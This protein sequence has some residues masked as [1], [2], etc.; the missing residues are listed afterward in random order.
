MKPAFTDLV[1]NEKLRRRLGD[2]LTA[3]RFGH[4]YILE[5]A[6][7]TGKHTLA[8]RIAMALACENRSRDG[9]PIPCMTCASCRKILSGNSPDVIFV[10]RGEKATIGV[11][12]V[13]EMHTDVFMPPNEL[14]NKVYI[15]ED[16]HLMTVQAQNAFLL[17][18]EEPPVYVRFLLLCESASM[19]LETVRSRAQTL[20]TEPIPQEEID[21]YL[22]ETNA[23]AKALKDSSPEDYREL[24]A[25][26][27]GSIGRAI[28]LLDP[29]LRQAI[30]D[31]RA[32]ARELIRFYGSRHNSA[33][34][35]SYL[36]GLG[37]KRE[38]LI[39]RLN[40]SLLAVRDL[41]LCKQTESAPLCFYPGKEEACAVAYRFTAP[42]LLR[43]CDCM[44]KAIDLL[45]RNA[46]IR[47]TLTG[48]A[49]DAGVLS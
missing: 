15:I 47:L 17:T 33:A 5:G 35:L 36:S 14:E 29:K 2:D 43:L 34:V 31:Q 45:R 16:A 44:D 41:L 1:G 24:L 46:N 48:F 25:A 4:A 37:Q 49:M 10:G 22:S 13:R 7:G 12:A 30:L 23:Q 40:V 39:E 38:D 18:L 9:F 28:R 6:A 3:G 11:E 19:L 32:G 20:R 26:A 42:E 21:R 27:G 8:L